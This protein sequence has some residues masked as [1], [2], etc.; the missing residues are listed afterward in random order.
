[1][2]S[3]GGGYEEYSF[4]PVLARGQTLRHDFLLRNSTR[5]AIRILGST[6]T[7]P[8][9]SEIGA[10]SR[11]VVPPG[12]QCLIP[13]AMKVLS[14]RYE[15][16]RAGF[17]IETDG[18]HPKV[19][20]FVL[21]ADLYPGLEIQNPGDQTLT[22]PMN[23]SGRYV[24]KVVTRRIGE[25]GEVP[26]EW[27]DAELPLRA[28]F[29]HGIQTTLENGRFTASRRDVEVELPPCDH[30]GIQ[31]GS[32][33]LGWPQGRKRSIGVSWIVPVP[34]EIRPRNLAISVDEVRRPQCITVRSCDN[35]PFR[36]KTI[37]P[38]DFLAE[39]S[40]SREA[41]SSHEITIRF[42]RERVANCREWTM[43]IETDRPDEPTARLR[44]FIIATM[45]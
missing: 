1:M 9:C 34:L 32:I 33:T 10:L 38:L 7:V 6:A 40:F 20:T 31:R 42:V 25:E 23:R 43:A 3:K 36:I 45:D 12:G 8:C 35:Q 26:P 41:R 44:V 5:R 28:R 16:K 29:I 19:S 27:V 2:K 15:R 22:L 39:A 24:L 4:G 21:V 13:T 37:G 30:S 18:N 14:D 11:D 17:I